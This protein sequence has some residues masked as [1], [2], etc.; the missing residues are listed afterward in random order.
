MQ[1][2]ELCTVVLG[3]AMAFLALLEVAS[4]AQVTAEA[5]SQTPLPPRDPRGLEA[6][7]DRLAVKRGEGINIRVWVKSALIESAK[8]NVF[9]A[10]DQLELVGE[11]PREISISPDFPTTFTLRGKSAGKSNILVLVTGV[12][13]ITQELESVSKEIQGIEVQSR[14]QWATALF[15]NSLLGVILGA[16]LTLGTSRLNDSGQRRREEDQRKRWVVET[17][18]TYLEFDRTAVLES[19]ESKFESWRTKLLNEGYYTVL[20]KLTEQRSS[21]KDL[22]KALVGV[23]SHLQNYEDFRLKNRLDPQF[24][25]ELAKELAEITSGIKSLR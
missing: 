1:S 12:N 2:K 18:P 11:Q 23:G 13:K 5:P 7:A 14:V 9:Y 20:E 22:A 4:S 3:V 19:Q 25:E 17:L 6:F 15:S 21:L 8:G 16:L 10:G 24:Q